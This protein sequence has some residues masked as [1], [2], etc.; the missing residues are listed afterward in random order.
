MFD[1]RMRIWYNRGMELPQDG[2]ILL[3]YLNMKLRDEY[4]DLSALCEDLE[5]SEEELLRKMKE[6]GYE[7]NAE[8]HR[9]L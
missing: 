9:F 7:Y 5:L 4:A 1:F 6:F 2:A 3:G 8:S